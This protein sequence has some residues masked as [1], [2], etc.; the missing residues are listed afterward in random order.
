MPSWSDHRVAQHCSVSV[1]LVNTVRRGLA[2]AAATMPKV[3]STAP[4][5][6]AATMPKVQSTDPPN[7]AAGNGCPPADPGPAQMRTGR[8]GRTIN[9]A[10]IG[11][12]KKDRPPAPPEK[13]LDQLGRE[14]SEE[15]RGG[16]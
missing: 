5:D 12:R 7:A 11:R 16:R 3:Q 15:R 14:G 8:D 13:V 6:A 2:E 9:T 4:L 10:N 1:H